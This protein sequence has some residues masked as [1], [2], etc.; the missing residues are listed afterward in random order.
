MALGSAVL[1]CAVLAACAIAVKDRIL[2]VYYL[3]QLS[4]PCSTGIDYD[5]DERL[6][7]LLG[8]LR[9]AEAVSLIL[10]H[11]EGHQAQAQGRQQPLCNQVSIGALTAIGPPAVPDLIRSLDS[12]DRAGLQV[13]ISSLGHIGPESGSLAAL[14]RMLDG[15]FK[16]RLTTVIAI[17]QLGP[18]GEAALLEM[19]RDQKNSEL[20]D[21]AIHML[22]DARIL[23][24]VVKDLGHE[25]PPALALELAAGR[26]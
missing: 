16:M 6:I 23:G 10:E 8:Q 2:E 12:M 3:R 5:E 20:R 18:P 13:A 11:V 7:L 21:W 15:D 1:G 14:I 19:L 17:L 4:H 22:T 24:H 26:R 25:L 9:S